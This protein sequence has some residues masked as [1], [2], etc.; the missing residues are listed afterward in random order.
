MAAMLLTLAPVWGQERG[1]R[2]V[3]ESD[4]RAV[5]S[6]HE[7]GDGVHFA[8]Q[9]RAGGSFTGTEMGKSVKG[10][11]KTAGKQF[12]W[13][14]TKPAGAEECYDVQKKGDEVR[15]MNYGSEAFFGK[16]APLSSR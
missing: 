3:R 14:W 15:F 8:Y 1:W 10:K 11:W 12:C 6:E 2:A 4:L 13:G 9:F 5:F 16:M 7:Y